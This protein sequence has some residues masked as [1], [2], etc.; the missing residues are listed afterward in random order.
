MTENAANK[1][2]TKELQYAHSGHT[3]F[4]MNTNAEGYIA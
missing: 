3:S 1:Q 4:E 2:L